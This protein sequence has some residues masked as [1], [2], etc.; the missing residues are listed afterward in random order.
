MEY[1]SGANKKKVLL[2]KDEDIEYRDGFLYHSSGFTD[3]RI[4]QQ[5]EDGVEHSISGAFAAQG[6]YTLDLQQCYVPAKH[7]QSRKRRSMSEEMDLDLTEED[8]KV[9]IDLGKN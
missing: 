8:L 7:M 2:L 5:S 1:S 6:S 9:N 3:I 4:K